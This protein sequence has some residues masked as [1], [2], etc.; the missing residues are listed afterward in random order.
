VLRTIQWVRVAILFIVRPFMSIFCWVEGYAV[1]NIWEPLSV[2][3][4]AQQWLDACEFCGV[5]LLSHRQVGLALLVI[6]GGE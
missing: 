4:L 2:L 1:S 5:S 3:G 6:F